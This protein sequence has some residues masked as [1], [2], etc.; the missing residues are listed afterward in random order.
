M[1]NPWSSYLCIARVACLIPG[2]PD[3]N[4]SQQTNCPLNSSSDLVCC[5]S[6]PSKTTDVNNAS[7]SFDTTPSAYTFTLNV[8]TPLV[9]VM[10]FFDNL[11][12]SDCVWNC[13]SLSNGSHLSSGSPRSH[14]L[15]G[16]NASFVGNDIS[17]SMHVYLYRNQLQVRF[18]TF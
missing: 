14:G 12:M 2:T 10:I 9:Y 4:I 1:F 17:S 13:S 18:K 8:T 3:G 7:K 5:P 11:N 16:I 6:S 15:N